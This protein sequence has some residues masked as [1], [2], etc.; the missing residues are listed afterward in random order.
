MSSSEM[1]TS[2]SSPLNGSRPRR[3]AVPVWYD[4]DDHGRVVVWMSED[5]L[6]AKLLRRAGRAT[7][8]V[9]Q[10]TGGYAYVSVEGGVTFAAV[11]PAV[12]S[13]MATR[14][15]GDRAGREFVEHSDLDGTV[16]VMLDVVKLRSFGPTE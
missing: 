10:E 14:Y 11:G 5:S 12:L 6:K 8:A 7:L 9:Q 4:V 15:L 16:L 3:F 2:V 1:Y 13:R